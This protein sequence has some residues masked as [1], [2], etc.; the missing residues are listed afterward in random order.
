MDDIIRDKS[1]PT[2]DRWETAIEDAA[3]DSI[4]GH[5]LVRACDS[6]SILT[7][8]GARIPAIR[9]KAMSRSARDREIPNVF[10]QNA[11]KLSG[12]YN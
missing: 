5:I 1:G 6:R 7:P 10:R 4:R 11:L 3:F 9:A 12:R 8:I 2:L